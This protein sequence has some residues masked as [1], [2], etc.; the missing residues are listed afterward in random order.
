MYSLVMN[1]IEEEVRRVY[2]HLE[3]WYPKR[4]SQDASKGG[5][6]KALRMR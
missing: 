4:H 1:L 2:R 5:I 3:G 6:S